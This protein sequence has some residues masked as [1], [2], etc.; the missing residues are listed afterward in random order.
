MPFS[1]QHLLEKNCLTK[2]KR[3]SNSKRPCPCN[4]CQ[5]D[6]SK[7][8]SEFLIR[9]HL[10]VFGKYE[11]SAHHVAHETSDE[12]A[13]DSENDE[14]SSATEGWSSE[15][16][17]NT[18]EGDQ[19]SQCELEVEHDQ[20]DPQLEERSSA[21]K[22]CDDGAVVEHD[23]P[24]SDESEESEYSDVQLVYSDSDD[25]SLT[26]A[27]S[28]NDREGN[29]YNSDFAKLPLYENSP[30]TVL[31]ALAG[32]LAWFSQ[33]PSASK[34]SI[35]E[36]LGLHKN[37]ILPSPNNLPSCY[38]EA[39]KL[40][41][42]FLLPY[43]SY[44]VCINEC[45]VFRKTSRYDHSKFKECPTCGENRFNASRIAKRKFSC[46]PLGPRLKR[47]FATGSISQCLQAH[48]ICTN[49]DH[50]TMYDVHDSPLWKK[51]FTED[52]F[53]KGDPRGILLQLCT[54]GVNPFS[55]NKVNYSMWPIMFSV[56]NLPKEVRNTYQNIMLVG[57]VPAQV[58]GKEPKSLDPYL[59]IVVDELLDL[60]EATFYDG[61]RKVEFA[62]KI[63]IFNYV[64]D[65]PG[66][67]KVLSAAGPNALRGCMWC[68]KRGTCTTCIYNVVHFYINV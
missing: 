60:S 7:L 45:V 57:I 55:S 34:T 18:G 10:K 64:L 22:V 4:S 1:A 24:S 67:T 44:D 47:M 25:S 19:L 20:N 12:L 15:D 50:N 36:L 63:D 17:E 9:R 49:N 37:F 31:Q 62:F 5:L 16:E 40:I 56:L 39:F 38:D 11:P 26:D 48:A 35:T 14:S 53:S 8:C 68:E 32:Y 41:K 27:E 58:E 13:T 28:E 6:E 42:P 30:V 61:Y 54:D 3:R 21:D 65:Y 66:L 59:E 43:I 52:G 2:R 46:Y 23:D 51:A 29:V 33:H